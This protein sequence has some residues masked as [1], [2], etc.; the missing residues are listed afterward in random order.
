MS[1]PMKEDSTVKISWEAAILNWYGV[2]LASHNYVIILEIHRVCHPAFLSQSSS[3]V[4][5][6][7][8]Q[9]N[10]TVK[11]YSEILQW[12][13]TVKYFP[14]IKY[15]SE[16]LRNGMCNST[17]STFFQKVALSP[18]CYPSITSGQWDSRVKAIRENYFGHM[19][20]PSS[21]R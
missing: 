13:I 1:R 16:V 6:T 7:L 10:T 4:I 8:V 12:Y 3:W 2:V 21:G 18:F 5:I 17:P 11:Y 19:P 14:S 9:W 20:V 15:C